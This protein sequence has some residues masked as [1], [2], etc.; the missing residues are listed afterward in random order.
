MRG[1]A[2]A[3]CGIEEADEHIG[4]FQEPLPRFAER[5]LIKNGHNPNAKQTGQVIQVGGHA[6]MSM[7]EQCYFIHPQGFW[8]QRQG[9]RWE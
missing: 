8:I 4:L 5:V 9:H 3:G 7:A 6:S 1:E 2:G